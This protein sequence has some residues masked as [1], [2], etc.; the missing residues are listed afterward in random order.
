[1]HG[2]TPNH[3]RN[4][5]ADRPKETVTLSSASR[6][7]TFKARVLAS[8]GIPTFSHVP[9]G[10]NR[11]DPTCDRGFPC[12]RTW[13]QT[14]SS[15]AS[16]DSILSCGHRYAP[17]GFDTN[18]KRLPPLSTVAPRMPKKTFHYGADLYELPLVN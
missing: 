12:T 7:A 10:L 1:M 2:G 18:P 6:G 17:P 8:M 15:R 13:R 9:P 11:G 4:P 14:S 5:T 3:F 16:P